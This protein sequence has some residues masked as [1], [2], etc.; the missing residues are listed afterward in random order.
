VELDPKLVA[1]LGARAKVALR[2]RM[3]ALRAAYPAATLAEKSARIVARIAELPAFEAARSVALF[4]PMLEKNEVDLRALDALAR[5]AKKSVYYPGF[6]RT[7]DGVLATDLRRTDSTADL[8]PGGQ[9][10]WE[11]P[12]AARSAGRGDV[13]LL[14]VP[15]LA[16]ALSG[17][18]L[19]FGI[20]F[21]DSLLP[22]FRP[23]AVAVVAAFDFQLL[24]ELPSESHDVACDAIVTDG[25]SVLL[26][27]S[28]T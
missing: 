25:R 19:G 22:D 28:S 2:Q 16:V 10:F 14:V 17:H 9:R 21:Y 8:A 4:W 1:E 27:A 23:P 26:A 11:P 15:A 13:E 24:A 12:A 5:E 7:A 6:T 18:R 20:G 3:K